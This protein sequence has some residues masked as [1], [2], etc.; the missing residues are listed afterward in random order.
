MGSA[1][2][3]RVLLLLGA[4]VPL[5]FFDLGVRVFPNNDEARFPM[6]A[7]DILS[8]GDWLLPNL[9]GTLYLKKPPLHAWLIAL[10]SW[11]VGVVTQVT[12]PLPSLLGAIGL[13]LVTY[14]VAKRLDDSFAGLAAGLVVA[15]MYGVFFLARVPMPDM[16]LT[17]ALTAAMAAFVAAETGRGRVALPLFYGLVGV[18]FW[19]KGP[20][21]LLPLVVV[22]A[23]VLAT[24]GRA[25]LARLVNVPG[26]IL[27]A[28]LVAPW[29]IV[30]ALAD[31]RRFAGDV[32][33][34][35]FVLWYV[36]TSGIGWHTVTKPFTTALEVLLPWSP[37]APVAVWTAFRAGRA[38]PERAR[39][40]RLLLV[41]AGVIFVVIGLSSQQRLRYYLPLCPPVAVLIATW[42]GNLPLRRRAATFAC[43]WVLVASGLVAVQVWATRRDN[44]ATDLRGI[45]RVID[46]APAPLYAA[47]A[48]ELVLAFYLE[49]P[50]TPVRDSRSVDD[51]F[52]GTAGGYLVI[53]G[54]VAT[55]LDHDPRGR[56]VAEGLVGG[57]RFYVLARE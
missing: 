42:Y 49:R 38:D 29:W 8:R 41:W 5:L 53:G 3:A 44:A 32:V 35:D 34:R 28:L 48:Q 46:A 25:G 2:L 54:R 20:V 14:W 22:V 56:R 39:G 10:A 17:L 6:L 27:L 51:Y 13:A 40:R 24:D 26:L 19:S 9:N 43:V 47:D 55:A 18:A 1:G 23:H 57:R 36:P 7:R 21:G 4:V 30:D 37:L 15:S 33:V 11:P 52:A 31:R 12:A 45:A 16:T 50:V